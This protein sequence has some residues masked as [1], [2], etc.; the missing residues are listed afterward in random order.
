MYQA[1]IGPE[2][3]PVTIL[4]LLGFFLQSRANTI[5]EDAKS[6][7]KDPLFSSSLVEMNHLQNEGKQ[8]V[9]NLLYGGKQEKFLGAPLIEEVVS[10]GNQ[11]T[12]IPTR[13]ISSRRENENIFH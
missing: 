5:A 1:F 7:R 9:E 12:N 8:I 6:H 4:K 3:C 11:R 13:E 10:N 2:S